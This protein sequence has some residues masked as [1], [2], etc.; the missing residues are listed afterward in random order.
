[1]SIV[2]SRR[3]AVWSS[4]SRNHIADGDVASG[5][6]LRLVSFHVSFLAYLSQRGSSFDG[7]DALEETR[8]CDFDMHR[9]LPLHVFGPSYHSRISIRASRQGS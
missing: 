1:M 8:I 6:A 3:L 7:T 4:Q 9:V 5:A 2:A